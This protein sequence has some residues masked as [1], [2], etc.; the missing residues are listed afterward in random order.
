[1]LAKCAKPIQELRIDLPTIG[2]ATVERAAAAGL[3]GI[4]G[5]AGRMLV[6]DRPQTLEAAD[7]LGVFIVGVA[8]PQS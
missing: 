5:E 4:V 2:V 7:R 3:A 1:V 8:P 6:M